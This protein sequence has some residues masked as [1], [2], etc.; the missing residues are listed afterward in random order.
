MRN[1]LVLGGVRAQATAAGLT[2]VVCFSGRARLAPVTKL[3]E[4]K[5]VRLDRLY[6]G[7]LWKQA[8]QSLL[9]PLPPDGTN[10]PEWLSELL[11]G[12]LEAP[13]PPVLP[14][15]GRTDG[16]AAAS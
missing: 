15:P 1:L 3:A 14:A 6:R 4:S 10:L 5:Q 8:E 12:V 11:E 7:A 13:K 9:V 2:E 16:L